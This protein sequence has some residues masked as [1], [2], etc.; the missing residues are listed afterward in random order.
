MNLTTHSIT[1]L[2]MDTFD[3]ACNR[4]CIIIIIII[5]III[6]T[7]VRNYCYKIWTDRFKK[8]IDSVCSQES[9]I[10]YTTVLSHVMKNIF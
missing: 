9:L 6:T 4:V 8:S 7:V 2:I 1:V 3:K 5:L 10:T